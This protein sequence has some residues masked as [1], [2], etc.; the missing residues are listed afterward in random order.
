MWENNILVFFLNCQPMFISHL[1]VFTFCSIYLLFTYLSLM[2]QFISQT[3]GYKQVQPDRTS[4]EY[5]RQTSRIPSPTCFL[6]FWGPMAA[7][8][9]E[10]WDLKFSCSAQWICGQKAATESLKRGS[11]HLILVYFYLIITWQHLRKCFWDIF[12][13]KQSFIAPQHTLN[14]FYRGT[15]LWWFEQK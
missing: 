5:P 4:T 9:N 13:R 11:A 10:F 8:T 12:N 7:G 2:G 15:Q 1:T 14:C 6:L 3:G